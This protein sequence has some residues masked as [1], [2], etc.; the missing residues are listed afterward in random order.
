[1]RISTFYI[2]VGGTE[3]SYG[4]IQA[5]FPT[6]LQRLPRSRLAGQPGCRDHMNRPLISKYRQAG[7]KYKTRLS[8]FNPSLSVFRNQKMK[9]FECLK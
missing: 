5:R 6:S 4:K 2:P 9:P 8:F 7:S 1:M 3:C